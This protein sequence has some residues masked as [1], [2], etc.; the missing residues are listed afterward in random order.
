MH[1]RKAFTLIELLVVIAIIMILIAILLPICV[2]IRNRALVLASPIAYVS[3]DLGVYLTGPK[4][5]YAV[6]LSEPEYRFYGDTGS[7]L[8][9][10]ACGRRLAY[11]AAGTIP[12]PYIFFHEPGSGKVWRQDGTLGFY[13]WVDYD[14]YLGGA[15]VTAGTPYHS[16]ITVEN[17]QFMGGGVVI[18]DQGESIA[19][20]SLSAVPA[21]CPGR[22]VAQVSDS[23]NFLIAFV[24]KNYRPGKVI[25]K[26]PG[27]S[28]TPTLTPRVDPLGEY[29][30]WNDGST[31][32]VASLAM[33]SSVRETRIEGCF[34][35]WTEK[36]E[37]LVNFNGELRVYSKDGVFIRTVPTERRLRSGPGM[38]AYRKYGHQ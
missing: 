17:R 18:G 21:V 13:G 29:I 26:F 24:G 15:W 16:I 31:T 1:R 22:Y 9:W 19:Y 20:H 33:G 10:S 32:C 7:P 12:A 37:V 34:C 11:E 30:A 28:T 6:R 5:G 14:H 23:V 3:D 4:G 27:G 25:R 8:M 36:G 2:K 35:D 38:A